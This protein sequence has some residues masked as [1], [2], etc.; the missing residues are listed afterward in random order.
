MILDTSGA[1][2]ISEMD[3]ALKLLTTDSPLKNFATY[4]HA[5]FEMYKDAGE[6]ALIAQNELQRKLTKL[7][8]VQGKLTLLF[9]L[10]ANEK[11]DTLM[12][13]Y[14]EYLKQVYNDNPIDEEYMKV[15]EAY[16][17]FVLLRDLIVNARLI[18]SHESGSQCII[19]LEEPVT[20]ALV[21]CGHT[22]CGTCMRKH[23]GPCFIC[24]TYAKDKLN[25]YFS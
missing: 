23:T 4:T 25:L 1:D 22:F 17:K 16:R 11:Y 5:I 8:K 24:R 19:C 2:V 12:A 18:G 21:P 7:D 10:D 14:E 20:Y 6:A 9:D 13:N 3:A 15:V